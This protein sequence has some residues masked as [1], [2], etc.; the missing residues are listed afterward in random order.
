MKN[1]GRIVALA[2]VAV[3]IWFAYGSSKPKIFAKVGLTSHAVRITNGNDVAW[4]SPTVILNDG[5][6]GP[7]LVVN[8][9]WPPNETRDSRPC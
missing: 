6:S 4:D 2:V 5:F 7:I 3:V 8:G 9:L 1:V